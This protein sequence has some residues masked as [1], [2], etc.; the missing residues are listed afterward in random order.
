[1]FTTTLGRAPAAVSTYQEYAVTLVETSRRGGRSNGGR[2]VRTL[3]HRKTVCW[4]ESHVYLT[5]YG[6]ATP[7][8]TLGTRLPCR[9][10]SWVVQGESRVPQPDGTGGRANATSSDTVN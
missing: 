4:T 1:M 7:R 5:V 2:Q 10:I 6:A 8:G 9:T 3:T